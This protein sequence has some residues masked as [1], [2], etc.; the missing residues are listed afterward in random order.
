VGRQH[1]ILGSNSTIINGHFNQ[2]GGHNNFIGGGY[3][4]CITVTNYDLV[5]NPSS[6][7]SIQAQIPRGNFIGNGYYNKILDTAQSSLIV[8]GKQNVIQ[9]GI[10]SSILGGF[11]NSIV[12]APNSFII[13]SRSNITNLMDI[14]GG[15]S[16]AGIISDGYAPVWNFE[17]HK[18]LINFKNGMI[19]TP[20]IKIS[21]SLSM[22]KDG[23]D[24]VAE[25]VRYIGYTGISY[26]MSL[27][28]STRIVNIGLGNTIQDYTDISGLSTGQNGVILQ[29]VF[30]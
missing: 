21:S 1:Y 3:Y 12:N 19:L 8:G 5:N 18:L 27:A 9:S 29:G 14:T 30:Y 10:Y 11:N 4:N 17:S 16:G 6:F 13:G 22:P 25:D 20:G 24:T 28:E 2:I 7:D 15:I 23:I 26:P